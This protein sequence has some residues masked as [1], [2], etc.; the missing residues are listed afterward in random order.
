MHR[1]GLVDRHRVGSFWRGRLG[2][3]RQ[4]V[5]EIVDPGIAAG[6]LEVLEPLIDQATEGMVAPLAGTVLAGLHI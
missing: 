5:G 1:D 6:R 4:T 3:C 2:Q